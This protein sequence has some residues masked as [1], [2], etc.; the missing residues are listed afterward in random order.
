MVEE[1]QGCSSYTLMDT[2][3]GL[4]IRSWMLARLL[5]EYLGNKR[6]TAKT[7]VMMDVGVNQVLLARALPDLIHISWVVVVLVVDYSDTTQA[8][9]H[10]Q[11]YFPVIWCAMGFCCEG[12]TMRQLLQ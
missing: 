9:D 2:V 11:H 6:K 1:V 5:L 3:L 8:V 10:P 12:I 4:R 7:S